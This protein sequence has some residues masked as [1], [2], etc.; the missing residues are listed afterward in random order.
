MINTLLRFSLTFIVLVLIQS[1]VLNNINLTGFDINPMLYVLFILIL[2]FETP[3]W[4]LL[5]LAFT[6]GI[7]IDI[8]CD[9]LG[10]HAFSSVLMAYARP[11]IL[12][13][14]SG[15]EGYEAG[16]QPRMVDQGK[17]WFFKY[18]LI[19]IFIHHLAYY[20]LDAFSL[21]LIAV[22]FFIVILS[23]FFTLV[24]VM[25]VQYFVYK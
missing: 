24:I 3:N 1:L 20:F 2:P 19:L 6:L 8:F 22:K 25:L 21:S 13:T 16:T 23:S 11:Y 18:A 5:I 12:R 15:R 9:S 4:F 7:T 17:N 14:L 10:L